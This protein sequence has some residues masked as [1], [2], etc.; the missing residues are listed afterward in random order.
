MRKLP[1]PPG[2]NELVLIIS[3]D[4]RSSTSSAPS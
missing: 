1:I 2:T 3:P 4:I